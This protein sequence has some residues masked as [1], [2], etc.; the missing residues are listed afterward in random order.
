LADTPKPP[1]G[2]VLHHFCHSRAAC[3]RENGEWESSRRVGCTHHCLP[4]VFSSGLSHDLLSTPWPPFLG[5][6]LRSWRTP[7]NPRQE[8]SCTTSVIPAQL[9]LVRTGSGESRGR[10]GC[11]HH[12][13]P[14]V[15][16][17]A[18]PQDSLSTPLAPHSW[19]RDKMG[20][21][22]HPRTPG[23][24]QADHSRAACPS[25]NGER[26]SR[27]R[28]GCAHHCLPPMVSSAPPQDSLST[29]LIPHSW[30]EERGTPSDSRQ[31]FLLHLLGQLITLGT[32]QTLE[33]SVLHF[34]SANLRRVLTGGSNGCSREVSSASAHG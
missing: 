33:R 30:G 32:S 29:P 4:L 10:V 34:D 1:A 22:G 21:E 2:S 15:F 17:S 13:L 26:E 3:P 24:P 19:G 20:A 14:L 25:G 31:E 12:C 11:A 18:P 16:S 23:P 27:G 7:P 9:V 5:G 8:V 28:V 6:R